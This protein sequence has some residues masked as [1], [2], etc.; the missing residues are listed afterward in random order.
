MPFMIP[1]W[2][3]QRVREWG[4]LIVK[5]KKGSIQLNEATAAWRVNALAGTKLN[6]IS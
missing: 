6:G 1:N 5:T 4:D 2:T 3:V